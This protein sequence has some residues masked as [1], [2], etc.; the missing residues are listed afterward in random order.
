MKYALFTEPGTRV[1]RAGRTPEGAYLIVRGEVRR[2]VHR[3]RM[4]LRLEVLEDSGATTELPATAWRSDDLA[5]VPPPERP[6]YV[7]R[8]RG[9]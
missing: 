8:G 1:L 3:P 9:R 7:H 2:R 6:A 4:P 5:L